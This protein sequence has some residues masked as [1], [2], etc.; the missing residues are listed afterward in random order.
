MW[1][2]CE[3]LTLKVMKDRRPIRRER[4]WREKN[5]LPRLANTYA[6]SDG[7]YRGTRSTCPRCKHQGSGRVFSGFGIW[8]K[9]GAGIGK[10]INILTGSGFCWS[11]GSGTRENLG[12][13]HP[14]CGVGHVVMS[15]SFI[16]LTYKSY[17]C[18]VLKRAK[19]IQNI[20]RKGIYSWFSCGVIIFQM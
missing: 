18:F 8:P 16:I 15:C 9:C 4:V 2:K 3:K 11:P 14:G 19:L 6:F 1:Q 12:T 10:T 7:E 13:D 20:S 5:A 17:F